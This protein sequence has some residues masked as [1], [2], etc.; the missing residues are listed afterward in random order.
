MLPLYKVRTD[1]A[2]DKPEV[3]GLLSKTLQFKRNEDVISFIGEY[4]SVTEGKQL[5]YKE[6]TKYIAKEVLG[7]DEKL[8]DDP[9][10]GAISSMLKLFVSK[11]NFGYVDS[12]RGPR[13]PEEFENIFLLIGMLLSIY[14]KT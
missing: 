8:I 9:N 14:S 3:L 5:I 4:V 12:L 1:I 7:M 10:I 2:E 13:T 11:Q 6:S